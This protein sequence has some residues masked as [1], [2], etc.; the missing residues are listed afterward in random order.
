MFFQMSDQIIGIIDF[1]VFQNN[2]EFSSVVFQIVIDD[3]YIS[4]VNDFIFPRA[5][6]NRSAF[7]HD[8]RPAGADDQV[9]AVITVG[10]LVPEN[11]LSFRIADI[12][13]QINTHIDLCQIGFGKRAEFFFGSEAVADHDILGEIDGVHMTQLQIDRQITVAAAVETQNTR[14]TRE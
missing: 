6:R 14:F 4:S 9:I 13:R 1:H 2:P 3:Q 11:D 8:T 12:V 7:E 5:Y 10:M